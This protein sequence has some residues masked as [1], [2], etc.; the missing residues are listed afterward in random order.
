[1]SSVQLPTNDDLG[2]GRQSA[3]TSHSR[4]HTLSQA[5]N[6]IF[7]NGRGKET[8][9]IPWSN[10]TDLPHTTN[11]MVARREETYTPTEIELL[12]HLAGDFGN[13]LNRADI[14]DCFLRVRGNRECEQS[15]QSC[16]LCRRL[17]GCASMC[18]C[19]AFEYL[20]W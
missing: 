17:H 12:K 9:S 11:S 6:F 7:G 8:R 10:P 19:C 2:Q 1:M 13:L 5:A 16:F 14:S 18:S 20:C 15:S 3:D 4:Q